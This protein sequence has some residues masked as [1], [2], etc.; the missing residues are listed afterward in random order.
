VINQNHL[1]ALRT[2]C[3]KLE[4]ADVNWVLGGSTNLALQRVDISPRDIDILTDKE[5]AFIIERLLKDYQIKR[6]RFTRSERIASYLGTFRVEGVEVEVMGELQIKTAKGWTKPLKPSQKK[7][8]KTE[9]MKIP[10]NPLEIE[11][12]AYRSLGRMDRV[13]KILEVMP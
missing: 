11:L 9:G 12:K 2:I 3:E 5:G 6:V 1:K 4:G 7:I 10:A 13:Q 8:L